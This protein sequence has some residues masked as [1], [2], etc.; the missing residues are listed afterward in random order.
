[1]A[2][3]IESYR[4]VV[5]DRRVKGEA[6]IIA[7]AQDLEKLLELTVGYFSHWPERYLVEDRVAKYAFTIHLNQKR[8]AQLEGD[9]Q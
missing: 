7:Y 3:T 4:Y 2:E 6:G 8:T 1:M 5:V 9:V